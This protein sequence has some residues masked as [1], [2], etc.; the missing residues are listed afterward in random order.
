M[1]DLI[2]QLLEH[3]QAH[4][5]ARRDEQRGLAHDK[6]GFFV[7]RAIAEMPNVQLGQRQQRRVVNGVVVV[8]RPDEGERD[9]PLV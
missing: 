1:K 4:R 2:S 3:L 5:L 8:G 6:R 9:Y 7:V